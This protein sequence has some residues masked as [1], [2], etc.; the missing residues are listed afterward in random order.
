LISPSPAR[1]F[2][3]LPRSPPAKRAQLFAKSAKPIILSG[4][5]ILV[6]M[7]SWLCFGRTHGGRLLGAVLLP[8]TLALTGRADDFQGATHMVPFEE[9]LIDYNNAAATGAVAQLQQ[10][11]DAGAAT[12]KHDDDYGY[13]LSVL[14]ELKVPKSSQM[15]VFSKTSLQRELISPQRP[16]ALFFNDQ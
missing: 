15:L 8:L 2:A 9:D 10:R 16:R 14:T 7:Q 4:P 6:V 1:V 12:L 13:L 3:P 5:M 11:L